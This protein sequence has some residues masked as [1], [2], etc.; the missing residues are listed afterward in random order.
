MR[1]STAL[2]LAFSVLTGSVLAMPAPQVS[3]EDLAAIAENAQNDESNDGNPAAFDGQACTD[4]QF[5][6]TCREDGR[7]G[8]EIPPNEVSFQEIDGQCG[9]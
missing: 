4:G 6:G 5:D 8:L 9:L 3:F 1:F 2:L 7:C